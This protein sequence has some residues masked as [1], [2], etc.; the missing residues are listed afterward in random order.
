MKKTN[1]LVE[2]VD[3]FIKSKEKELDVEDFLYVLETPSP[4]VIEL[5]VDGL[6]YDI[7]NGMEEYLHKFT[8]DFLQEFEILLEGR[9][10]WEFIEPSIIHIFVK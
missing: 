5:R 6:L 2:K 1:R 3:E 10:E 8:E 4:K 7:F 9:A